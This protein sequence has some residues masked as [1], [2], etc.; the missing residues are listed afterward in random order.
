MLGFEER[1]KP[2]FVEKNPSEQ[3]RE[4]TTNS[5]HIWHRVGI[6]PRT[7]W[8]NASPLTNAPTQL[9]PPPRGGVT[10]IKLLDILLWNRQYNDGTQFC[11]YGFSLFLMSFSL[12]CRVVYS[13]RLFQGLVLTRCQN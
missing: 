6:E 4:P 9:P 5:T 11:F 13:L 1:G 2:E 8:W 3:N 12:V 7:H 10:I